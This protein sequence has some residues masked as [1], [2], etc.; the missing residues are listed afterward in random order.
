MA[1]SGGLS[2]KFVTGVALFSL[3]AACTASAESLVQWGERPT[4]VNTPGTN[5]VNANQTILGTS[6]TYSGA[7]NNPAVGANYYPN[8]TDRSP[9]FSA[10]PT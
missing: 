6:T 4:G 8:N 2:M 3:M 7:T 10:W 9:H 5:I 1:C